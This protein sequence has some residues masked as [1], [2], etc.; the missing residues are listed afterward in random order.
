MFET[1]IRAKETKMSST[2]RLTSPVRLVRGLL[3]VLLASAFA[4]SGFTGS[5]ATDQ[6]STPITFEYITVYP[7]D[8]LWGL[9]GVHSTADPRDWIIDVMRLNGLSSHELTPGQQLALP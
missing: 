8:S 9:A 3:I 6:G 2:Y 4:V 1:K 7:G 5:V